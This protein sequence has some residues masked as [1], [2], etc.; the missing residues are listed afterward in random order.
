KR[1]KVAEADRDAIVFLI[2]H[3]LDLSSIMTSRDLSDPATA[4]QLAN[5]AGTVE[6]LKLLTLLTFAD[7]SAVNPTAMTPWRREQ[8]W[9]VYLIGYEELT[10]ALIS[11][12]IT[13]PELESSDADAFL[14]GFP[15]R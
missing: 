5:K 3:H 13:R 1:L 9:R 15:T 10:R 11:D 8:L 12:R 4:R 14:E 6:R 2:E 7:I